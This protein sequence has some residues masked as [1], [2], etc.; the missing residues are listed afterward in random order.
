MDKSILKITSRF[1]CQPRQIHRVTVNC[2]ATRKRLVLSETDL[3]KS[4][5]LMHDYENEFTVRIRPIRVRS[6]SE[7]TQSGSHISF[8]YAWIMVRSIN[9]IVKTTCTMAQS[10]HMISLTNDYLII[11][12]CQTKRFGILLRIAKLQINKLV[13]RKSTSELCSGIL[14][15]RK[16]GRKTSHIPS[17]IAALP[18]QV[19]NNRPYASKNLCST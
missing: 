17:L 11:P 18:N 12:Y 16:M 9:A 7:N 8:D 2:L 19:F 3:N 15:G 14:A 10:C 13:C 4:S 6:D 5:S 1:S